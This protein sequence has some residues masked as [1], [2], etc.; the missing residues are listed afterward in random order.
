MRESTRVGC[1]CDAENTLHRPG[2]PLQSAAAGLLN[3]S[4]R[5]RDRSGWRPGP[6]RF[7]QNFRDRVQNVQRAGKAACAGGVAACGI[8]AVKNPPERSKNAPERSKNVKNA[9]KRS[10]YMPLCTF[11]P[12]FY[13]FPGHFAPFTIDPADALHRPACIRAAFFPAAFFNLSPVRYVSRIFPRS[14]R[15]STCPPSP[16]PV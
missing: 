16:G 3:R 11:C 10:K 8:A 14:G 7:E 15:F 1:V 5:V 12:V 2:K 4:E 9:P 6:G 13:C